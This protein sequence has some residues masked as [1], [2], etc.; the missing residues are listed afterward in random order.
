MKRLS[1]EAMKL[2]VLYRPIPH[3]ACVNTQVP[4]LYRDAVQLFQ[5]A[6]I[7]QLQERIWYDRPDIFYDGMARYNYVHPTVSDFADGESWGYRK[8]YELSKL[9]S[10]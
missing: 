3:T 6:S 4:V 1:S 7:S 9:V 8:F 2:A 5:Q 10:I